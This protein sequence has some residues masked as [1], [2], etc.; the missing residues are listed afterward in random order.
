MGVNNPLKYKNV[1]LLKDVFRRVTKAT[2]QGKAV[3]SDF[4]EDT[5]FRS[6]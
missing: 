6:A 4:L 3:V 2:N 1:T 5:L